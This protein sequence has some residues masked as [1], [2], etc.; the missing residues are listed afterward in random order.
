[1]Y[2]FVR[3]KKQT[4]G[5][6]KTAYRTMMYHVLN[7]Y[8]HILVFVLCIALYHNNDI[9]GLKGVATLHFFSILLS[10]TTAHIERK[11]ASLS[12]KY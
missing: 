12:D 8:A 7:I 5:K 4:F 10:F 11:N 6:T 9:N 1:M 3:I 2:L